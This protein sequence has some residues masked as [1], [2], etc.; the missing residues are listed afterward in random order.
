MGSLPSYFC[1]GTAQMVCDGLAANLA[2]LQ[3]E[4]N[5]TLDLYVDGCELKRQA[6]SHIGRRRRRVG[7]MTRRVRGSDQLP[8]PILVAQRSHTIGSRFLEAEL[9]YASSTRAARDHQPQG[10]DMNLLA[11]GID[12]AKL[13][14]NVCLINPGG[15]LKHKVFA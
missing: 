9:V 13:K 15:K 1:F 2:S 5:L 11:L 3:K 6:T 7:I 12:I 14:F 8:P 10:V 4:G